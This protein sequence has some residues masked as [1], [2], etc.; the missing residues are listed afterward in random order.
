MTTAAISGK[1][2]SV[3]NGG[4][5]DEITEWSVTLTTEALDATSMSSDGW[6]EFIEGLQ[7]ATGSFTAIGSRPVTGSQSGIS[8]NTGNVTISGDVI[9]SSVEASTPVDGVVT[10][11]ADFSFTGEVSAA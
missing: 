2:G 5:A 10:Y 1:A 11:S 7:G 6:R 4:G 3:T 8:L 9:I